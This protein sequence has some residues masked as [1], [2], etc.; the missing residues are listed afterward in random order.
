MNSTG[1]VFL[2]A[3]IPTGDWRE[4]VEILRIYAEQF[5]TAY[6][7][8]LP[9]ALQQL[10]RIAELRIQHFPYLRILSLFGMSFKGGS[11]YADAAIESAIA[12]TAEYG[13][14]GIILPGR[15]IPSAFAFA[16][17]KGLQVFLTGVRLPED[18]VDKEGPMRVHQDPITPAE[19]AAIDP[20]AFVI[21][22]PVS[23]AVPCIPELPSVRMTDPLE[24]DVTAE[25]GRFVSNVNV[26]YVTSQILP[27]ASMTRIET[28]Y[29]CPD[30][31]E[32]IVIVEY[33]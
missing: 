7:N 13:C 20:Y 23:S 31:H 30:T 9:A 32:G 11:D 25:A 19:V 26:E 29:V 15:S 22:D 21:G 18:D 8:L 4:V 12:T 16:K 6:V 2:D 27:A 5:P 33:Q 14:T 17:Q 10:P 1:D 3:K 28:A 24:G